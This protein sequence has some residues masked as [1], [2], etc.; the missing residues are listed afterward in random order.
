MYIVTLLREYGFHMMTQKS[1]YILYEQC[2]TN[3]DL[4]N[5]VA[6]FRMI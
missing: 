1:V 2:K 5:K 6:T 4:I 3:N